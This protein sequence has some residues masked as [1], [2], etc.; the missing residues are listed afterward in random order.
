[1]ALMGLFFFF[2]PAEIIINVVLI[3]FIFGKTSELKLTYLVFIHSISVADH[4]KS[5]HKDGRQEMAVCVLAVLSSA[6][7]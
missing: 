5:C 7:R 3:F 6:T 1:L 4:R 2:T